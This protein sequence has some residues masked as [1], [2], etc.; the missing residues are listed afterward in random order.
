MI[1]RRASKGGA[2]QGA[3]SLFE[4]EAERRAFVDPNLAK[5][6][7]LADLLG[8]PKVAVFEAGSLFEEGSDHGA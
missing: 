5:C 4:A 8:A 3:P 2:S 7:A 1:R 6:Q